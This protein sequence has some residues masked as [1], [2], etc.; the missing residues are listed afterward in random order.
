MLYGYGKILAFSNLV[1]LAYL[2][3]NLRMLLRLPTLVFLNCLWLVW[4]LATG[5]FSLDNNAQDTIF[6]LLEISYCP[7]IFMFFY[8]ATMRNPDRLCTTIEVF[9]VLLIFCALMFLFV[10]RYHNSTLVRGSAV[11]NDVYYLLLLL[12]WILLC[13]RAFWKYAG[14][15]LIAVGVLLSMKRTALFAL[16]FALGAYFISDR[17]RHRKIISWR[18]LI[19]IATLTF[20]SLC[21]YSYVNNRTDGFLLSRLANISHDRGS[22]RLDI[23]KEVFRLQG[24][25]SI[26]SWVFGHGHNMVRKFNPIR[27]ADSLSAHNDWQEVLFDYGLPALVIYCFFHLYLLRFIFQLIKRRSYFGPSMAASYVLLLMMSLTS[28]LVLYASYFAYLMA[29][30]GCVSAMQRHENLFGNNET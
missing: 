18:I 25:S 15:T 7:L 22:G 5:C 19:G 1:M 12:P 14:I 23:Y 24:D 17:I 6:G 8:L 2:G 11:L 20:I 27:G 9:S 21:I 29:L 10:F 28:H 4:V 13:P 26:D 16:V 3:F 30:W